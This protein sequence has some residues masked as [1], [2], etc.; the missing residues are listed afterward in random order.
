MK[1]IKFFIDY[2][3]E[4]KWLN[5]MAKKGYELE[6]VI[7][8]YKFRKVKPENAIIRIDFRKFKNQEDFIDYSTL[9][10]DSGWK[11]IAGSKFYGAQYFKKVSENSQEDIFS[12]AMSKAG[13]YKRLSNMWASLAIAYLPFLGFLISFRSINVNAMMNPKLLYLTPGL[14]EMS[15]FNFWRHFLFE[16]PFAISRG[17]I[18]LLIPFI[19]I[20]Y[21]VC[22][23]KAELLY[24]KKAM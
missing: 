16:T 9:F 21:V 11:H 14:W 7:F 10:E 24:R 12:D 23:V 1:K 13:K 6:D 15:G 17:F 18:W 3:K 4:E 22:A 8:T 19:I 5:D 2:D 20:I